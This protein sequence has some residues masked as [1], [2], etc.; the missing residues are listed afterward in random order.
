MICAVTWFSVSARLQELHELPVR[1][2]ADGADL[3]HAL[4]LVLIL[5]GAGFHH[6]GHAVGPVDL[7][8]LEDLDHVDVDEVDAELLAVN[9]GFLHFALRLLVN[10]VTCCQRGGTGC[11]LD[12]RVGILDVVFRDPRRVLCD[13]HADV[14]LFEQYRR[15]VAAQQRVAQTRLQ[16]VPARGE[17]AG[18]VTDVLVVHQQHGAEAMCLHALTRALQTVCAQTLPVDALLPIQSH[19]AYVCHVALQLEIITRLILEI[20]L[21]NRPYAC[22]CR[23]FCCN[24]A[25]DLPC[26]KT[27]R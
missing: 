11:A 26:L 16:A 23:Y 4:V 17:G 18:H 13:M 3:A 24:L 12:P 5:D 7:R 6:R 2:V 27:L 25:C 21:R 19:H 8:V 1:G 20:T 15:V 22:N 10:L 14:A 9:T